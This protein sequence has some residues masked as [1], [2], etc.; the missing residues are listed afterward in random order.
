MIYKEPLLKKILLKIKY[1]PKATNKSYTNYL[2]KKG[3][4]IGS[5]VEFN[6]PWTI[7]IDYIKPWLVSIGNN[8][9]ISSHVRII[10]H[11]ADRR[12]LQNKYGDVLGSSGQILIG[13]NVFIGIGTI[14]LKNVKIGDN[15]VIGAGSVVTK[16]L[17]SNGVYAGNPARFIMSLDDFY[18]KRKK[19][20]I[21]EFMQIVKLYK[22]RYGKWPSKTNLEEYFFLF[23]NRNDGIKEYMDKHF[24]NGMNPKLS[25]KTFLSSNSIYDSLDDALNK[26][27]DDEQ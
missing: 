25:R 20:Q 24:Y 10:S 22:N 1:G 19:Q 17:D 3:I 21:D 13:D 9:L 5:N 8:V 18:E 16:N 15:V 23:E 14:I 11:G 27:M 7:D 4:I 26:V 12:I 6:S 2:R